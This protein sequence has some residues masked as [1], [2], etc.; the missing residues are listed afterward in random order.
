MTGSRL[1]MNEKVKRN[2]TPGSWSPPFFAG[3]DWRIALCTK[4]DHGKHAVFFVRRGTPEEVL[5][6]QAGTVDRCIPVP[7]DVYEIVERMQR[8]EYRPWPVQPDP[9]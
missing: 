9:E 8:D 3:G 5:A 1:V 6:N 4:D 2:A 7:G